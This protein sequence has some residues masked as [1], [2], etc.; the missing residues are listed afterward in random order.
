MPTKLLGSGHERVG[1]NTTVGGNNF[2][3]GAISAT[4]TTARQSSCGTVTVTEEDGGGDDSGDDGGDDSG[5]GSG[6]GGFELPGGTTGLAL[7]G[8]GALLILFIALSS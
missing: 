6:D 8:V 2:T 1:M 7:G 3:N 5:D 4:Q